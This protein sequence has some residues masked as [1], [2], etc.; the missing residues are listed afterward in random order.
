MNDEI[1]KVLH[2]LAT[3]ILLFL[4]VQLKDMV[5]DRLKGGFDAA[6]GFTGHT[7]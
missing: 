1:I 6:P 2:A 4:A 7:R 3:M 5:L